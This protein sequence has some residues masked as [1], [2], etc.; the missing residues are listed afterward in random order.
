[1]RMDWLQRRHKENC[2][3]DL[4]RNEI[5]RQGHGENNYSE[6]RGGLHHD[7]VCQENDI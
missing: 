6:G 2:S 7:R 3:R 5:V 1:M 4:I